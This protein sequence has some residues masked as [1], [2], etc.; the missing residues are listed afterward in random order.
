MTETSTV[1]DLDMWRS[2]RQS[3]R[4]YHELCQR[5]ENARQQLGELPADVEQDLALLRGQLAANERLAADIARSGR[6][7]S[8]ISVAVRS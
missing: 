8:G 6:T 5:V 3:A 7:S 4:Q 1:V 2:L